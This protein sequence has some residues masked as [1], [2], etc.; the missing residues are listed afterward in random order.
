[1]S[2]TSWIIVFLAAFLVSSCLCVAGLAGWFAL[3]A[4]RSPEVR[5]VVETLAAPPTPSAVPELILTPPPPEIFKTLEAL[6]RADVPLS[7][8]RELAVRL[9]GAEAVPLVVAENAP[10]LA[11]GTVKTFNASDVDT[12]ENFTLEA[13]LVYE[14]ARD[15]G[16]LERHRLPAGNAPGGAARTW[17]HRYTWDLS[18]I[19]IEQRGAVTYWIEIRD[20][21]LP[22]SYANAFCNPVYAAS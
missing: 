22:V 5:Q 3:Q 10:P 7:D 21:N 13:E 15:D 2:R 14:L 6:R 11:V 20:K 4:V 18:A 19:P 1:M 9:R 8:L 12:N 16:E 17:Q